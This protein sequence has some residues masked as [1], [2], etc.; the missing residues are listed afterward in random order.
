MN[1]NLVGSIR[2]G[3][4]M[5]MAYLVPICV[6]ILPPQTIIDSDLLISKK[7]FFS[8]KTALPN[9]SKLGR[10][11]PVKVLYEDY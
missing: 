9:E 4:S 11:H 2:G 6:Q 1:R 5:K 7:K 10:K 8:S 3:F